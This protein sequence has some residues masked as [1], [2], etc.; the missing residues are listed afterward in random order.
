MMWLEHERLEA[1]RRAEALRAKVMASRRLLSEELTRRRDAG[2][3]HERTRRAMYEPLG[4]RSARG[5]ASA[6]PTKAFGRRAEEERATHRA[7]TERL[8][9]ETTDL[10]ERLDDLRE[11]LERASK[12]SEAGTSAST[13][14]LKPR[15]SAGND[16]ALV[17]SRQT[18]TARYERDLADT[19]ESALRLREELDAARKAR[20]E[21]VEALRVAREESHRLAEAANSSEIDRVTQIERAVSDAKRDFDAKVAAHVSEI[22]ELKTQLSKARAD[23][24]AHRSSQSNTLSSQIAQ[25]TT[26]QHNLVQELTDA[27][28]SERTAKIRIKELEVRVAEVTAALD[29]ATKEMSAAAR[30][31]NAA[32]LMKEK[33]LNTSF[34]ER[35][36]ELEQSHKELRDE[37]ARV[38]AENEARV[39]T[40]ARLEGELE[41]TAAALAASAKA[42]RES[43]ARVD[44]LTSEL[45]R[46]KTAV[47]EIDRGVDARER[48]SSK[49]FGIPRAR[50]GIRAESRVGI[51][52]E[53][54]ERIS[55]THRGGHGAKHDASSEARRRHRRI[56]DDTS[57]A[58]REAE[59]R[60]GVALDRARRARSRGLWG[61]I[62]RSTRHRLVRRVQEEDQGP[63]SR[64]GDGNRREDRARDQTSRARA[65]ARGAQGEKRAPV[66]A[67]LLLWILVP[68][69]HRNRT[70]FTSRAR[71]IHASHRLR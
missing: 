24:D 68:R 11:K 58:K 45:E 65:R 49:E 48:D 3:S 34:D 27:K 47:G 13:S 23:F 35:E 32:V 55:K 26:I 17:R 54:R 22:D 70:L 7:K 1:L 4:T 46:V 62:R 71:V 51:V 25:Q 2:R 21:A 61:I 18:M 41:K 66:D 64:R 40:I 63:R 67:R 30:E 52:R 14:P 19:R 5:S 8:K 42:E 69:R 37:M 43:T 10:N 12:E 28:T 50:F 53:E 44:A 57:L 38:S 31:Q 9:K 20:D 29:I 59:E 6:S 39:T 33:A 56:D 36:H 16:D 15:P 60:S